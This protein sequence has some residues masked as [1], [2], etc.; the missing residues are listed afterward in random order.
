GAPDETIVDGYGRMSLQFAE[1]FD[2]G[3]AWPRRPSIEEMFM[4]LLGGVTLG[5]QGIGILP[6]G[7]IVRFPPRGPVLQPFTRQALTG[8][9]VREMASLIDDAAIRRTVENAGGCLVRKAPEQLP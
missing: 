4:A 5:G 8:L 7:G 6:G 2:T 9:V 3:V 1:G